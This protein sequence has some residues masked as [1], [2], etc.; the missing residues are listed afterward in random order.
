MKKEY[1]NQALRILH[2]ANIVF[3]KEATVSIYHHLGEK[4]FDKV[5]AVFIN[6]VNRAYCKS[7]VIMLPN[8]RY[9]NHYHKIKMESFYILYGTLGIEV[10][11]VSRYLKAGEMLHI[12]RGED[13]SFWSDEGVVFEEISTNYTKNDSFYLDTEI[14]KTTYTKRR[15][16]IT[17]EEWERTC[18]EWK[19]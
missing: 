10:N 5:G 7:Y 16:I 8:Q 11:G 18:R 3:S 6:I 9:P 2:E 12:E 4:E 19:R 14:Q 15:T 13:H 17:L 1:L